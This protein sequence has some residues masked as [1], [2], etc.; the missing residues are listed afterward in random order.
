MLKITRWWRQFTAY[1]WHTIWEFIGWVV[2]VI[3]VLAVVAIVVFF[4]M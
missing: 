2:T 1:W 3:V 4:V